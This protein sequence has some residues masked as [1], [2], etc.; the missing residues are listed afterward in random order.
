MQMKFTHIFKVKAVAAVFVALLAGIT[1]C[2]GPLDMEFSSNLSHP[3]KERPEGATLKETPNLRRVFVLFSF[4]YNNLSYDLNEDIEEMI[5]GALPEYGLDKNVVL[6][7]RHGTAKNSNYSLPSSPVLTHFYTRNGNIVRDTLKVYSDTTVASRKSLVNDVLT[8]AKNRFPA[9]SYGMLISSHGTG[10]APQGY[11]YSPKDKTSSSI[12]SLNTSGYDGPEKYHQDRPLLKSIGAH[13]NGSAAR[14]IEIEIP[15]LAEAIP[16]HLDYILFDA[17]FMGCVEVAYELRDKCDQI[18]FSQTEVL[19][20]GMDYKNLLSVLFNH[21]DIDLTACAENYF[22][23]YKDQS[24]SW[25]RSA[26][27]SVVDC[28][29]L[30]HLAEI[31]SKHAGKIKTLASS[32]SLSDVQGY[33]QPRYSRYHGIFYDLKDIVAKAGATEDELSELQ[34]ALDECVLCKYTTARFLDEFTIKTHSGL[35]MYLYDSDRY[36]LN[37]YYKS[38]KWEQDVRLIQ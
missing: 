31:V 38:L 6:V 14:S 29:K 27:V 9:Q 25:M 19:A 7:L 26:T 18:C 23:M 21:D 22:N 28:S 1:S 24:I 16:M 33:F 34:A 8:I 10:W 35:S 20:G 15:D 32:N 11:C 37:E 4:G 2:T 36:I 3:Q 17:C 12:W 5:K 30:D 13:Y